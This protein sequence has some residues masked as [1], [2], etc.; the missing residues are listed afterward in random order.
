MLWPAAVP[1]ATTHRRRERSVPPIP[2]A[3]LQSLHRHRSAGSSRPAP[4]R[5]AR[6]DRLASD[7]AVPT[8][9]PT[10]TQHRGSTTLHRDEGVSAHHP[11]RSA[12]RSRR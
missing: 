1:P 6:R 10:G 9:S 12:P 3:S 2:A 11:A 8:A 5:R 4:D 7:G